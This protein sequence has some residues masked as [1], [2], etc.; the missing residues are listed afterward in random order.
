MFSN[1]YFT[2]FSMKFYSVKPYWK[3]SHHYKVKGKRQCFFQERKHTSLT[4]PTLLGTI[5]NVSFGIVRILK[6]HENL[7]MAPHK[8]TVNN[9]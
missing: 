2:D 5:L 7:Y 6:A 8:K 9:S 1:L 3:I 4:L